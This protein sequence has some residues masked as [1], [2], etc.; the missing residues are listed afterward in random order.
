MLELELE[1][2]LQL[3]RR[4]DFI[5]LAEFRALC[6]A[7]VAVLMDRMRL[8]GQFLWTSL[9]VPIEIC[10]TRLIAAFHFRA[11]GWGASR[12]H[13]RERSREGSRLGPFARARA[14]KEERESSESS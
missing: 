7:T 4:P 5:I 12:A 8:F 9:L 6:L 10:L 1:L 3:W 11:V 2:E 14:R 13:G